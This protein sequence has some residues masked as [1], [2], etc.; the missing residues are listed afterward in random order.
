[1]G[2]IESV[3]APRN[4]RLGPP[5]L[6]AEGIREPWMLACSISAIQVVVIGIGTGMSTRVA[7]VDE[8]F[9]LAA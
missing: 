4:P 6:F 9:V 7:L 3:P 1:M 8:P 2:W 5:P